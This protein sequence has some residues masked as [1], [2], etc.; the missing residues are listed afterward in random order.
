MA[1]TRF[2]APIKVGPNGNTGVVQCIQF[3]SFDPTSTSAD[4][5]IDLPK[6]ARPVSIVPY[7]GT[8][9]GTNP[10]V[11]I[12]TAT[13]L[14][15]FANEVAS[16][17]TQTAPLGVLANTALTANT[18]VYGRVGASAATGGTFTFALV[19]TFDPDSV[20]ANGEE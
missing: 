1:S 4:T 3:G 9:G 10:T 14:A 12:G 6:G 5:G 16:D 13:S 17:A 19:Y 15:I 11:D 2:R 18:P 8:T 7:G 20:A